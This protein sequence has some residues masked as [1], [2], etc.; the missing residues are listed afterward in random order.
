ML[1]LYR[2]GEDPELAGGERSDHAA[3][4]RERNVAFGLDAALTNYGRLSA[5]TA[6]RVVRF[7][8]VRQANGA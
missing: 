2:G 6:R 8:Q 5:S 7:W 3:L 4:G 1:I